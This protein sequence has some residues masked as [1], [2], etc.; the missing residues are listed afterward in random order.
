MSLSTVSNIDLLY[1]VTLVGITR[2]DYRGDVI[3]EYAKKHA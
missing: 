1:E 3:V 2:C